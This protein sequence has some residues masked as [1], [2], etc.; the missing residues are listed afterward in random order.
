MMVLLLR[1]M[2]F[3]SIVAAQSLSRLFFAL[4]G[5]FSS[6]SKKP[7]SESQEELPMDRHHVMVTNV[8]TASLAK[9]VQIDELG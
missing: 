9:S 1:Q 6:F 2:G 5:Y 8:I 3:C 7:P 4:L